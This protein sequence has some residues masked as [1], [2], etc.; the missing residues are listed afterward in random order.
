[1]RLIIENDWSFDISSFQE[2]CVEGVHKCS[3]VLVPESNQA[4]HYVVC[5]LIVPLRPSSAASPFFILADQRMSNCMHRYKSINDLNLQSL[6]SVTEQIFFSWN[7][8][9][10]FTEGK[11]WFV[12]INKQTAFSSICYEDWGNSILQLPQNKQKKSHDKF[13][14]SSNSSGKSPE[15][16]K[17]RKINHS[18]FGQSQRT[19][20][21]ING[22]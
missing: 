14:E 5:I 12:L 7:L 6:I 15:M 1:M 16:G 9:L 20:V 21:I 18:T 17:F 4:E 22:Q 19:Q 11:Y 13:S 8:W 10:N 2:I 3:A